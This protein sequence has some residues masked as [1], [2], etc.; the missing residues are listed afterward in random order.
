MSEGEAASLLPGEAR[1]RGTTGVVLVVGAS[2]SGSTLLCNT[3]GQADGF[4]SVGELAHIWDRGLMQNQLCGCGR[5]FRA[6]HFWREVIEATLGSVARVEVERI[7]RLKKAVETG[8]GRFQLL[9][10]RRTAGY[11]SQLREYSSILG[12]LLRT[13][14]RVS[15]RTFIVDSS[16]RFVHGVVLGHVDGVDLRLV[17]LLRDARAVAYSQQRKKLRPEIHWRKEFM[18]RT[19]PMKSSV[20]WVRAN[21]LFECLKRFV[22]VHTTVRYEDFTSR[23]RE[24]L[25]RVFRE[26]HLAAR[27]PDISAS[28]V[29]LKPSHTVSGNPMRFEHGIVSIRPDIEWRQGMRWRHRMLV[30]G[31]AWPLLLRYGYFSPPGRQREEFPGHASSMLD[32]AG[33]R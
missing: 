1:L 18:D 33:S 13:I 17:H 5:P 31:L 27:I 4:V 29:V 12:A 14:L 19:G 20:G 16:K 9:A 32:R 25:Q 7:L 10:A 3:L 26:L 11:A 28:K 30:S 2:R 8:T 22:C 23:A 24:E 15:G 6:C 21:L